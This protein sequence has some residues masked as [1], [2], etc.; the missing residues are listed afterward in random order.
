M[1]SY[2]PEKS[3]GKYIS[4]FWMIFNLGAVIGSLVGHTY[5]VFTTSLTP[6]DSFGREHSRY[7]K[8]NR[9]RWNLHWI[10]CPDATRS[11]IGIDSGECER[12][13]PRRWV[14]S[15]CAEESYL[16]LRINGSR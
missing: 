16:E 10:P 15:H 1:M 12:C 13:H 2:P 9:V 8:A 4:W 3:K 7:N 14:E 11:R 5:S 6:L